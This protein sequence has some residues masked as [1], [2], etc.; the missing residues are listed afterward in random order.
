MQM[1]LPWVFELGQTS[2]S[3]IQSIINFGQESHEIKPYQDMGISFEG[4][5]WETPL[6]YSK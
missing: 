4:K 2:V 3:E 1:T 5:D 6:N